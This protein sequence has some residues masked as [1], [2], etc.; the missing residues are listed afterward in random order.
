MVRTQISL[1]PFDVELLDRAE[2][3]SGASRAELI[4]RAIREH[5][6]LTSTLEERRRRARRGFGA[7]QGRRFTG[8]EF[9]RAVRS[10]DMNDSLRRLDA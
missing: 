9:V 6:G 1:T 2:R 10:G 5:Y 7:W 4:R 8:D 3:E